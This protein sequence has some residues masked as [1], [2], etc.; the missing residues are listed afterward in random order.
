VVAPGSIDA[1]GKTNIDPQ[2]G[3]S[4]GASLVNNSLVYNIPVKL[5]DRYRGRN[6]IVRS[7]SPSELVNFL[8]PTDPASVRFMQLLATAEDAGCLESFGPA[9]P[10]EIVLKDPALQYLQLYNYTNLVDTHPVR[11][12]VPVVPGFSKAT[13]LA[14]S[15]NY[16]VRLELDQP[17]EVLLREVESVLDL[18]LHRSFVNQPVEF[19]HS[20]LLA[21]YRNEPI[22][23]WEIAEE[24]P[25]VV[26]YVSDDGE[27]TISRRFVGMNLAGGLD[28]FVDRFGAELISERRECHDC[29][30]FNRCGGYFKWPDRTY[31]CDGIKKLLR[32]LAGTAQEVQQDLASFEATEVQL[33]S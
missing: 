11:I 33:Q 23:L 21:L 17:D 2:A 8:R 5:I 26:R 1:G 12:A 9:I 13:K 14:I 24:D 18:Y 15:L 16:G 6:V 4:G 27:E 29:E 31:R 30:F 28:D 20:M 19:F 3:I 32:T 25:K 7:S 22:T 10:L